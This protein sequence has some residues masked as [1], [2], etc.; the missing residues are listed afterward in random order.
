MSLIVDCLHLI[1]SDFDGHREMLHFLSVNRSMNQLK[2][3]V[4]FNKLFVPYKTSMKD[5]DYLE[6]IKCSSV[7]KDNIMLRNIPKNVTWIRYQSRDPLDVGDIP[8]QTQ[9]IEFHGGFNHKLKPG[10]IPEGVTHVTFGFV[11]DQPLDVGVLPTT[12]KRVTFVFRFDQKLKV[13]DIPEGVTHL[14]MSHVYN[15]PFEK[16]VLPKSLI[17][18]DVGHFFRGNRNKGYIPSSV[19][20]GNILSC[21]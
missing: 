8:A 4:K 21:L 15:K 6:N 19:K 14:V 11:Y 17:H 1:F 12:T 20:S 5:L 9:F 2:K 10:V 16:D 7:V 3:H 18:L 13:G